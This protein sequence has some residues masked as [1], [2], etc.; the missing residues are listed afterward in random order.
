MIHPLFHFAQKATMKTLFIP[1]TFTP[2]G[3]LADNLAR[4]AFELAS[5]TSMLDESDQHKMISFGVPDWKAVVGKDYSPVKQ[6]AIKQGLIKANEKYSNLPDKSF[7]K[8]VQLTSKHRNSDLKAYELKR[9]QPASKRF[10]IDRNDHVGGWLAKNLERL[11]FAESFDPESLVDYSKSLRSRNAIRLAFAKIRNEQ[12]FASRC[13]Y[14]RFHSNVTNMSKSLRAKL[15]SDDHTLVEVDIK[16][17]PPFLIPEVIR[18]Y[19]WREGKKGKREETKKKDRREQEVKSKHSVL[20]D[21]LKNFHNLVVD[22]NFYELFESESDRN[23]IKEMVFT[24]I[25]SKD[26]L[27]TVS[28]IQ[29]TLQK[30][31]P[32]ICNV[33][34]Q[35]K[36]E[37]HRVF[38]HCLQKL[39][40]EIV[41]EGACRAL[42][43]REPEM[44][45]VTVHV[46][47]LPRNPSLRLSLRSC[48]GLLRIVAG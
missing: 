18:E 45:I 20:E 41:I 21:E 24:Y 28:C 42:M 1:E 15:R 48:R 44:P 6:A 7:P 32:E 43:A 5:R 37:D 34:A 27:K 19:I 36:R 17:S 25:F 31:F 9:K 29:K 30:Q 11:S 46:R 4:L 10:R 26:N 39:E 40:S 22:G 23:S 8:S 2:K 14:G 35:I 13:K 16:N 33:I 47:F 3:P 38:A 12:L